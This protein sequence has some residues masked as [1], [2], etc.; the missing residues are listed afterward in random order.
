MKESILPLLNPSKK[1]SSNFLA[2]QLVSNRLFCMINSLI[3]LKMDDCLRTLDEIQILSLS[4][5][6]ILKDLF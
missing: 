6:L 2:I 4:L 5:K 1:M 3:E